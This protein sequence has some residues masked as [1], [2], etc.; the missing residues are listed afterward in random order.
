[1]LI[2]R[3]VAIVGIIR[4]IDVYKLFFTTPNPNDDH[5]H[6]ITLVY[7]SVE[8]NLA[9][10]TATIPTLRPLFRQWFPTLFGGSSQ[11]RRPYY[12]EGAYGSRSRGAHTLQSDDRDA[13]NAVS[14]KNLG[15]GS[16]SRALR[17]EV[18]SASPNT[19]EEEIMRYHGIMRTTNVHVE[20]DRRS[21]DRL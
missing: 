15:G 9:I 16:G 2:R 5:Y 3:S 1:M 12:S 20:Y 6:N 21:H 7:S 10:I 4:V 13:S 14:L 17:T 8:V 18:T 11:G 19:S